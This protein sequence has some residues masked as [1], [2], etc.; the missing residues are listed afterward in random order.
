[1]VRIQRQLYQVLN[2]FSQAK[3]ELSN[4]EPGNP[5]RVVLG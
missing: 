4:F 1:M 2:I 5:D 3:N